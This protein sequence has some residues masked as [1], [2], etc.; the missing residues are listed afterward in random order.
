[1]LGQSE[2]ISM[3]FDLFDF[4]KDEWKKQLN[5]YA[6]TIISTMNQLRVSQIFRRFQGYM[7]QERNAVNT[8]TGLSTCVASLRCLF[9]RGRT[10]GIANAARVILRMRNSKISF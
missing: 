3:V 2:L 1:M 7:L 8:R 6:H 4:E 9:R 10:S 5:L